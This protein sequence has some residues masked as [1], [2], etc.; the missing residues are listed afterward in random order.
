MP[1]ADQDAVAKADEDQDLDNADDGG[2]G[3][4]RLSTEDS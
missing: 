4:L 2:D 3:G 1:V